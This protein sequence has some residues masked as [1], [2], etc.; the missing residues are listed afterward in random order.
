MRWLVFGIIAFMLLVLDTSFVTVMQVRNV[1]PMLSIVLLVYV[2][3]FASRL[4]ALTACLT[5][6]LAMDLATPPLSM[7][8][9]GTLTLIGPHAIGF[10]FAGYLILQ[11]RTMVFRQRVITI[12][13]LTF[14]ATLAAAVV[15]TA[16]YVVRSWYGD[17]VNYPTQPSA[18]WSFL[19]WG[20]VAIY[21]ALIALPLGW[22][23]LSTTPIWHFSAGHA[24]RTNW[25]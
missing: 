9:E 23:L 17:G 1:A 8:G 19:R 12:S 15:M 2:C 24:H 6:G 14:V 25:R 7:Q 11:V 10:L 22:M 5:L 13:V 4:S 16:I 20:G 18:M 21:S 3:L